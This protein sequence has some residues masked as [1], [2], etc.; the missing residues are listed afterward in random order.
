MARLE[1]LLRTRISALIPQ[2]IDMLRKQISDNQKKINRFDREMKDMQ[3][4]L[5]WTVKNSM[6]A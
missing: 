4:T 1:I 3:A 2:E 5:D 6:H